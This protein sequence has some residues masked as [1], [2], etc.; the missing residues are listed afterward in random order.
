MLQRYLLIP[1]IYMY[2]LNSFPY[3]INQIVYVDTRLLCET[4]LNYE[5][6]VLNLHSI[7]WLTIDLRHI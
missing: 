4:F 6:M 3:I 2:V 5:M 7:L 1:L